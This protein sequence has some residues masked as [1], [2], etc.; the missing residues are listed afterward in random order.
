MR[1]VVHVDHLI[2]YRLPFFQGVRSR[3]AENDIVYDVYSG[4]LT[5]QHTGKSDEGD[6]DWAHKIGNIHFDIGS[7]HLIWQPVLKEIWNCNLAIVGQQ[8]RYLVNYVAQ[9]LKPFRPSKLAFWG[10]GK[11]FQAEAPDGFAESWKRFWATRCDW[12]FGYTEETR[13]IVEGYGF[14][15]DRI[16]VFNN[17]I[18]TKKYKEWAEEISADEIAALKKTLGITTDNIAIYVGGIYDIKRIDFL[19]D[20]AKLIRLAIPDFTLLIVGGGPD[21]VTAERAAVEN[22]WIKYLGPKF[23][24]ENVALIKM[25]KAFLMPG[26]VGL[27]ILDCSAV[28]TPMITTTYPFHGPEFSYIRS[29]AN[30]LI[31]QDWQSTSAYANAVSSVLQNQQIQAALS[32]GAKQLANDYSIEA[33]VEKFCDGVINCLSRH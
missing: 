3:L 7:T 11:N 22:S 1:R 33:M 13:R 24:R 17:S 29:G 27:A 15:S 2:Q 12:W 28:G 31:V 14:P 6:L 18:D 23:G 19:I 4:S 10:H 16:T 25:S 21:Q 8:N 9:T 30:G 26:A 32:S 5:K 20:A